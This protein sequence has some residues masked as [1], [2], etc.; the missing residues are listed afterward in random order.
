[1]AAVGS[2]YAVAVFAPLLGAVVAGLFGRV[3]GDRLSVAISILLMTVASAGAVAALWLGVVGGSQTI[4]VPISTWVQAGGFH[5]S[6]QLRFDAL[7]A[8]MV[9]MVTVVSTLIHIYSAG[10]M[11]GETTPVSRFFAYLSLFT[12]AMLMLVS[13]DNLIQLFFG[14]EGVGLASYLLIGYWY[15]RP[16]ATRAAVK[17]FVVNRIADLFF[18][19]GIALLF[20]QF[21]T[22]AYDN[23]FALVPAHQDSAYGL[24][25]TSFRTYEVIG[26]LLFIGAAGKSAQLFLHV[27][28]PDAMEGPTPVSA[29]IHAATMVTAGVFLMARMSPLLEF[30]PVAKGIVLVIGASTCFFAA[31]VGLV[32]PDIKRTIAYSTCSQL[33]YMFIGVGVGAY[34]AAMFHLTTHACFKAL[35]FLSAGSVIHAL[36]GEQDMFRMGGL[37]RR[38]PVSYATMWAGSLAIAA[39]P[40]FAGWWS[41]DAIIDGAWVAGGLGLYGWVLG[42]VTAFITAL[43]SFRLIFLVFHGRARD[44]HLHDHAHESPPVMVAPLLVLSLGAVFAGW[45]L[46]APYVGSGQAG[47]WNG[48]IFSGADNHVLAR[49][50]QLPVLITLVPTAASLLGIAVA[51]YCYMLRPAVPAALAARFRGIY[52]FLLNKWYFDELYDAV[53]VRPYRVL[54]GALWHVA[55]DRVIDGVP[56]GLARLTGNGSLQ[57]V[58]IQTGSIAVYAFTMLVGLLCLT[59]VFLIF[60]Q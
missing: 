48:S 46:Y 43:Y 59:S 36:G 23:I 38:I 7:A 30:A 18:M 47:F 57:L 58:R 28:L 49:L 2:L 26:V 41:K 20:L 4:A 45:L 27:W 42:V 44:T 34:Q 37:W 22:V 1:M 9:T 40:P 14:W 11:S 21:G 10:Y 52:L 15:D 56:N 50:E 35:L 8:S 39:I 13:S 5:A 60:R 54:A 53:L 29:L 19:V 12:F 31:T 51:V 32:Q 33:G 25:G 6:W 24:F 17:A 3:I 55:D 16:N